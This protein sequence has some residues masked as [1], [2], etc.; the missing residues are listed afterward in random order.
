VNDN[1]QHNLPQNRKPHKLRE[2]K[3][4][5]FLAAPQQTPF[6]VLLFPY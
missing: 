1:T 3:M 6:M 2:N 4:K 5:Q